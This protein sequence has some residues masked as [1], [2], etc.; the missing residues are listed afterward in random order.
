MIVIM[1]REIVNGINMDRMMHTIRK[2]L[3]Q[4]RESMEE[5]A[6]EEVSDAMFLHYL[7]VLMIVN[8]DDNNSQ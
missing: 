2:N 1:S 6:T 3:L 5:N 4:F 7:Y 8:D